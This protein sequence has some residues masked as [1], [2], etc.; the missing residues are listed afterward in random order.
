MLSYDCYFILLIN[1]LE[2]SLFS[3]GC[4]KSVTLSATGAAAEKWPAFFGSFEYIGSRE[5]VLKEKTPWGTFTGWK[6][7]SA[8]FR[9]RGHSER[10]ENYLYDYLYRHSDGPWHV[11]T[12][13]GG[14]GVIKSVDNADCP[15]SISQWQYAGDPSWQSGDITAK[16][17]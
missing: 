6:E 3:P 12:V 1:S 9:K 16:C 17:N 10:N 14:E 8:V 7:G 11:S 4:C 5:D 15:D 13:I 2:S